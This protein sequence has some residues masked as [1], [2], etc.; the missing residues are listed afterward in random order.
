MQHFG[1]QASGTAVSIWA[2]PELQHRIAN[3]TVM[4]EKQRERCGR[5]RD[6]TKSPLK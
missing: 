4:S 3:E 1:P 2:V 6:V 5:D